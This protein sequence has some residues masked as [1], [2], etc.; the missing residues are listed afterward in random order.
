MHNFAA[1][2]DEFESRGA[3]VRLPEEDL[4]AVPLESEF[5]RLLS[6]GALRERMGE[7][8]YETATRNRGAV[9]RTLKVL[10]PLLKIQTRAG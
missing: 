3:L 7:R 9:E 10:E 2:A 6:D 1:T 5:H 4:P 8:A